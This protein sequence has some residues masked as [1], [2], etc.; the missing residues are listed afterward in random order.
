MKTPIPTSTDPNL[1]ITEQ[2]A[3]MGGYRMKHPTFGKITLSRWS[4]SS[5]DHLFMSNVETY[6]GISIEISLA[7][8]V[9]TN[10]SDHI[11]GNDPIIRVDLSPAQFADLLTNMNAEGT[12][13]T[14]RANR[15]ATPVCPGSVPEMETAP[16]KIEAEFDQAI[17]DLEF[18]DEKTGLQIREAISK[19]PA[20]HQTAITEAIQNI[21]SAV[22][23]QLPYIR[24]RWEDSLQKQLI[25]AKQE[26]AAYT[27]GMLK[28]AGITGVLAERAPQLQ[29]TFKTLEMKDVSPNDKKD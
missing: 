4:G 16:K 20:K 22:K 26:I 1:I 25:Q 6:S 17:S 24:R 3:P 21:T 2:G 27:D 14:I 10:G 28:R 15:A 8:L 13:C 23:S 18:I 29:D 11:F 9:H 7:E 5:K 19:L 12:P